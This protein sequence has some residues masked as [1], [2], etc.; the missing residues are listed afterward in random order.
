MSDIVWRPPA[1][2]VAAANVTRLMRRHGIATAEALQARS[3]ADP[4]WFWDAVVHDLGIAFAQPYHTVRDTSAGI[5]WTDWF[6]G[7]TLNIAVNCLDRHLA[8]GRG[9][10]R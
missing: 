5:P 10:R 7:G 3:V 6:V 1:D 9:D 4:E 8:G 2:L